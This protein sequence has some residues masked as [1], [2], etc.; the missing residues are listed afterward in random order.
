MV[1][2]LCRQKRIWLIGRL[3][4]TTI[5]VR[6]EAAEVWVWRN[7]SSMMM[8][9]AVRNRAYVS[10]D[11][12]WRSSIMFLWKVGAFLRDYIVSHP[13]RRIY[14]LMK[15]KFYKNRRLCW[16]AEKQL[17]SQGLSIPSPTHGISLSGIQLVI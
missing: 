11:L 6:F 16:Q 14:L 12:S 15:L 7:P 2:I 8:R 3:I 1:S 9:R 4:R 10:E 5:N 17:T 13:R